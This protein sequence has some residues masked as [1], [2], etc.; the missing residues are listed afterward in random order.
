MFDKNM[1]TTLSSSL[2]GGDLDSTS[3]GGT[4]SDN[5]TV[6][7]D[8]MHSPIQYGTLYVPNSNYRGN[9]SCKT[10]LHFDKFYASDKEIERRFCDISSDYDKSPPPTAAGS[11]LYPALNGVIY[12]N[13]VGDHNGNTKTTLAND[14]LNSGINRTTAIGLS[15]G[16]QLIPSITATHGMSGGFQLDRKFLQF[17][18]DQIQCM[19]EALQQKGDIEKLTTFLCS[20]PASELFK[21]NES[22][23]RARALVAYHRG[24]F[25]EL[26]NL[27]ETHCFSVKYH[28]DLQNL[29]FKAHYKEA[30]KVRG[31]PLGA[32]DKYR[33]R[34]KY[35]LPKTIWDGEETVYCF[36]EKSRNALKDC[37]MTNRYPT[38]DEKKTLAKKTGLTL[39][40]VSNWFK[41][42]RQRDRTPQQRP[43]IMSVLPVQQLDANGFPRMFNAPSY[44]PESIFNTQ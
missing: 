39:T 34:K 29:W 12:E 43:D 22:V 11:P 30:E 9:I 28:I 25:H 8:N 35:P 27:L 20:L 24:Q 26:Y 4:S 42:R 40:Q 17:T 3:S 19:C 44:Y 37:Y 10:V 5:S 14:A 32:V 21:T 23:L 15:G 1:D 7:H 18:T 6:I 41:N 38:P 13:G 16:S 33:L 31:R 36:K 2:H